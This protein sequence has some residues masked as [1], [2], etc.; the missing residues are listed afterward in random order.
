MSLRPLARL[1][2]ATCALAFAGCGIDAELERYCGIYKTCQCD[3]G[4]C[5]LVEGIACYEGQCCSG[6]VCS[7]EGT[8]VPEAP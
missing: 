7:A 3:D 2:L 4:G 5:C 8:C 1:A 6:L